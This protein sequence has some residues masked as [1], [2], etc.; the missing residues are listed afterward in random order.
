MIEFDEFGPEKVIE[1]YHPK[2]GMHGF[3]VIDNTALGTGKGGVRMTPD[4]SLE[5]VFKLARAMTWKCALA[6]L[7]FGGAK[8]GIKADPRKMSCEKKSEF[9]KAFAEAIREFVPLKY[10]PAPDMNTGEKEMDLIAKTIG[11][12][13]AATGKSKKLGGLP[14]ELGSTGFGVFHAAVV[15]SKFIGMNLRNAMIAVEGF[16][17]VGSFAAKFLSEY[18]AKIVAV[19]DIEGCVYNPQGLSFEGLMKATKEK[20]SVVHYSGPI[21]KKLYN[22]EL[23]ELPV[24]VI[25]TAAVPNVINFNNVDNVKAKL[26]VEGSNIPIAPETEQVLHERNVLVVPDIIAN[27][28]GVISSY[29]EFVDGNEHKMFRMVE[30]KIRKNVSLVLKHS[31]KEGKKPRDIAMQIARKRVRKKCKTCRA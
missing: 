4:V 24:D 20:C 26:I 17:N 12:M 19:S 3:I 25:I 16:G 13:K 6:D 30:S 7:P 29:A 28:G 1:V 5:E 31:K 27:A 23:F 21:T 15:A 9:I 14:H 11:S 8:S 18:G 10:V 22:Y 2:L